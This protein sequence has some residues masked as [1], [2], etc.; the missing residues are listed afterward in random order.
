[1]K[2]STHYQQS[3]QSQVEKDSVKIFVCMRN[4][5]SKVMTKIQRIEDTMGLWMISEQDRN[6]IQQMLQ[7]GKKVYV[8]GCTKDE[9]QV[10]TGRT[11]FQVYKFNT[12]SVESKGEK[13]LTRTIFHQVEEIRNPFIG[14]RFHGDEKF[15]RGYETVKISF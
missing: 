6:F 15:G 5:Y 10:Y 2:N 14:I 4:S 9:D 8:I 3:L 12:E 7:Y 11:C 1:M 13:P